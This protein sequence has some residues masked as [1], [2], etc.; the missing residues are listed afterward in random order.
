MTRP[1]I[2]RRE[3]LKTTLLFSSNFLVGGLA[4]KL[5]AAEPETRF[6]PGGIDLIAVG[7]YGSN[8]DKQRQV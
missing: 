8:N 6:S 5:G 2:T 7:D 3:A 1:T 4:G